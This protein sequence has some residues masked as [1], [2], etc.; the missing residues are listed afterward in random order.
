MSV[1]LARVEPVETRAS[2][3]QFLTFTLAD[4]LFAVPIESI[5]EVI[6]FHGI[7]HIPLAPPVVPGV[8]NL[9]GV[10][11]PIVDL[12]VR[13]GR[14]PTPVG[15]RTCVIVVEMQFEEGVLP[16]GVIVDSV[17]EAREAGPEQLE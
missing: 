5:R 1:A 15:R 7:T 3:S 8:L 9:R 2:S 13:F 12:S 14:A 6:E 16:I 4:E 10:V 17:S 11:I